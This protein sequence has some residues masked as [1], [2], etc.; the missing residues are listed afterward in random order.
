MSK[1]LEYKKVKETELVSC[2]Q[3]EG[4]FEKIFSN[5]ERY[6]D[7]GWEGLEFDKSYY[8]RC[9]FELYKWRLETDKEYEI[10]IKKLDKEEQKKEKAKERRR[11]QYE[12]LKKEFEN[13]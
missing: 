10:R 9:E 1:Y 2:L 6:K 11:K 5:L 12:E 4:S 13:E 3:L 8:Y 7:E